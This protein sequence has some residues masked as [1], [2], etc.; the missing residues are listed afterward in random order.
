MSKI[1]EQMMILTT[2]ASALTEQSDS[3]LNISYMFSCAAFI[4]FAA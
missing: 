1:S 3:F 4:A 2:G